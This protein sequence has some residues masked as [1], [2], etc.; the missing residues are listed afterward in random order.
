MQTLTTAAFMA[1]GLQQPNTDADFGKVLDHWGCG[2]QELV[3]ELVKYAPIA[4]E[5]LEAE[6][7][8]WPGVA[9]YEVAEPFGSWFSAQVLASEAGNVPDEEACRAKL[10]ELLEKFF[11]RSDEVAA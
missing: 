10:A 3:Q 8:V 4:D 9:E 7:R 6:E 1:T 5:L 2:N 11:R